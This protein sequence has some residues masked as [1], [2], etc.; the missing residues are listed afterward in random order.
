MKL[1]D[2]KNAVYNRFK[3]DSTAQLRENTSFQ[4]NTIPAIANTIA[5]IDFR[6]ITTWE[7]IYRCS[8]GILPYEENEQGYGCINGINIF[9]YWRPWKTFGLDGATAT[10][11]D[12]IDAYRKLLDIYHPDVPETGDAK[13]FDRLTLMYKSLILGVFPVEGCE[14]TVVLWCDGEG[15]SAYQRHESTTTHEKLQENND[16]F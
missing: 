14:D 16:E 12:I 10:N 4:V 1:Q 6:Y 15:F 3:V 11:Q 13:I 2:I 8:I 5:D 9:K 7:K